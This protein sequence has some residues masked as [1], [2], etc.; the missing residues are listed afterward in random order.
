MLG[1]LTIPFTMKES[2]AFPRR[3]KNGAPGLDGLPKQDLKT[4][5]NPG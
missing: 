1:G 5:T 2:S 4:K 3:M